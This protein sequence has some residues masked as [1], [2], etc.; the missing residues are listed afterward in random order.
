MT[1]EDFMK[2]MVATLSQR[3]DYTTDNG[4]YEAL[5]AVQRSFV[6]MLYAVGWEY[7]PDGTWRKF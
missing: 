6:D 4:A 3:L 5:R 1:V 2:L 7:M